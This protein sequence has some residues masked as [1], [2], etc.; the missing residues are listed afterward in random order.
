MLL[1][2]WLVAVILTAQASLFDKLIEK[3]L[4]VFIED[5]WSYKT[6]VHRYESLDI[7]FVVS[8]Q[9][10]LKDSVSLFF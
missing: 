5:F 10:E 4:Y 6:P 2:I 7:N 9:T 8:S 1:S 3:L